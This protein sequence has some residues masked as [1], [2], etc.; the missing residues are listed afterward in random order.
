MG[1]SLSKV[2]EDDGAEDGVG[3]CWVVL[4][5]NIRWATLSK[6]KALKVAMKVVGGSGGC[7]QVVDSNIR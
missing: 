4:D 3:E 2:R 7:W 1:H 5:S 6:R